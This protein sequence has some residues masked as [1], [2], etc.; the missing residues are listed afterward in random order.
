A[1]A[2]FAI[3]LSAQAMQHN[4]G[5]EM[6]ITGQVID[7]YCNTTSGAMGPGHKA[8]A[9]ACAKS[10]EALAILASD[11]TIYLPV[12]SKP[13]DPQNPRLIPFA[14]G[15]VRVTGT[16]RMNHGLHTIEITTIEAAT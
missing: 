15:K 4:A 13:A 12:S 11:G 7:T 10:G 6:T 5:D 14:E 2:L 9:V 3:P 8:C 16:H 1:L